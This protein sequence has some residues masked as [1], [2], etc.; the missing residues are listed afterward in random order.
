[1]P[2]ALLHRFATVVMR[3][4]LRLRAPAERYAQ[5]DTA[6]NRYAQDDTAAERYAQDD[7]A[8]ERYAQDDTS[9]SKPERLCRG[10]LGPLTAPLR[11]IEH[12]RDVQGFSI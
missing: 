12:T 6:A 1:M 7:T 9:V 3:T 2:S 11:E 4:V 10:G 5:D 8:A